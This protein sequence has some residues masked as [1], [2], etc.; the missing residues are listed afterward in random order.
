[1]RCSVFS[2]AFIYAAP[3]LFHKTYISQCSRPGFGDKR[4]EDLDFMN[5]YLNA[6]TGSGIWKISVLDP[7]TI[8]W[9]VGYAY[10][11]VLMNRIIP[12]FITTLGE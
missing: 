3:L 1:M 8:L 2:L 11:Q 5:D 7:D 10:E 12:E 9:Q 6:A 4:V